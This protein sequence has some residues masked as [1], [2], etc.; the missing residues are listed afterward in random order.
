MP[1]PPVHRARNLHSVPER[2]PEGGRG[3]VEMRRAAFVV[4]MMV[5][6]L[7]VSAS[8]GWS[9]PGPS[10]AQQAEQVDFNG[11][12]FADL[13]VGAP[14]EA[15]GSLT[16]AGALNVLLG[17]ADGLQPSPVVFFQGGG[18]GGTAERDDAFGA[19]VAKGDFNDDGFFDAAVGVPG[20]AV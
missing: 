10:R 5:A 7:M 6:T 15:V 2:R 12:G 9:A 8:P 11:D 20:E 13:A 1:W 19:A 16:G 18:V 14:G 4:A 17:S 3:V